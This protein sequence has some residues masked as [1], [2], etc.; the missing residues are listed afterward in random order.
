VNEEGSLS[1]LSADGQAWTAGYPPPSAVE[2]PLPAQPLSAFS[3]ALRL[4]RSIELAVELR[5]VLHPAGG[6][7]RLAPYPPRFVGDV[8]LVE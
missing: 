5:R 3:F 4:E 6:E 1:G 8:F 2:H 7:E